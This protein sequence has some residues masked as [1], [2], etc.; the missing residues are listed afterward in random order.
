MPSSGLLGYMV[1]LIAG[2]Y[3]NSLFHFL[4]K[5]VT[6]LKGAVQLI[7]RDL[8]WETRRGIS[9]RDEGFGSYTHRGIVGV[10]SVKR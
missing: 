2:S 8:K 7:I 9:D 4:R 1:I 5:K 3:V 6:L 10:M